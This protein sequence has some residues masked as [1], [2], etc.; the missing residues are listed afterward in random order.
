MTAYICTTC[1]VQHP[2][3]GS[4]PNNCPICDDERQWVP[5]QGQSW[6][7]LEEMKTS[8]YTNEIREQE[9][10][11]IG[12]GTSPKFGIGQRALLIQ[13]PHGNVLWECISYIDKKTIKEVEDLG[14]IQAISICHPH[15][16]SSMVEWSKAF[17]DAPIYLHE[18][19][20]SWVMREHKSVKF[21]SAPSIEIL[22]GITVI[23][24]GG[25]FI[26]STALHWSDGAEGKGVL[27]SGDTL[28]VTADRKYVSFLYSYPNMIP[29]SPTEVRHIADTVA[30]YKFDRVYGIFWDR[31]IAKDG[32]A[33]IEKSARR[34]IKRVQP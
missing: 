25:H 27:M 31:I 21:F 9:P 6:T 30:K 20:K 8:G 18:A 28:Q 17:D 3:T 26:G 29:L 22:P 2:P 13:T 12:I 14:G 32:M 15:F 10:S 19:D 5:H 1:G 7:T 23:H 24:C 33:A 34:Y 16:Y 4:P 11:V